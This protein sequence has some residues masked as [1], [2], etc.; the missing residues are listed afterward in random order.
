MRTLLLISFSALTAIATSQ[1]ML[2]SLHQM[3]RAFQENALKA[4]SKYK[5]KPITFDTHVVT[6]QRSKGVATIVAGTQFDDGLLIYSNLQLVKASEKVA[7]E[8]K[9][10]D[11][12]RVTG[13]LKRREVQS[14]DKLVIS[15]YVAGVHG[16]NGNVYGGGGD[17]SGGTVTVSWPV[18][19]VTGAKVTLL[20]SEAKRLSEQQKAQAALDKKQGEIDAAWKQACENLD[21]SAAQK[22]VE[23]GLPEYRIDAVLE[24][25]IRIDPEVT[26]YDKV[27]AFYSELLKTKKANIGAAFLSALNRP[28]PKLFKVYFDLGMLDITKP[29][30]NGDSLLHYMTKDTLMNLSGQPNKKLRM[31]FSENDV[32]MIEVVLSQPTA[33]QALSMKDTYGKTVIDYFKEPVVFSGSI[34][35]APYRKIKEMIEKKAS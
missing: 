8:L 27:V 15:G 18:Y 2:P 10:N 9:A 33:K 5:T 16:S 24:E 31:F 11:L 34:S 25:I 13:L 4:E 14:K 19:T 23:L 17:V 28:R 29:M 6:V 30:A 20:K 26:Y 3:E 7:M 21:A 1:E 35:G 32:E 12:I 22:A